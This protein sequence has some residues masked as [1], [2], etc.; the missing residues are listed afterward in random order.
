MGKKQSP[1]FGQRVRD[2]RKAKGLS[3]KDFAGAL[4]ISGTFLSEIENGKYK[5]GY[6]FFYNIL[7]KFKVNL[8][9]LLAGTGEM[10]NPEIK[11]VEIEVKRPS[12]PIM[13]GEDLLWYIERSPM[14]MYL[15]LGYASKV[16]Y[17]N[18]PHIDTEIKSYE[19][20]QKNS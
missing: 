2:I 20:I 18:K 16:L 13:K 8:H 15:V 6:E 3:Q 17:E 7:S 9:F 12:G 14:F 19:D 5:P 10:F 11:P 4:D 1:E